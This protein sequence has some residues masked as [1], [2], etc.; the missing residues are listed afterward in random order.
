M[1]A[2][3][4]PSPQQGTDGTTLHLSQSDLARTLGVSRET[5]GKHLVLWRKAGIVELGRRRLIIRN[6]RALACV[7]E[8]GQT[9]TGRAAP[10]PTR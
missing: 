2:A 4:M 3:A 8:E 10:K 9:E 6:S 1:L 5:V 7:S